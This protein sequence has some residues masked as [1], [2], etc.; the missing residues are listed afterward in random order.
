MTVFVH[1][2]I[3]LS[4]E[5]RNGW[6]GSGAVVLSRNGLRRARQLDGF[7]ESDVVINLGLVP[8]LGV[9]GIIYNHSDSVRATL[10]PSAIRKT[11]PDLIPP[12]PKEPGTPYWVKGP[13]ERGHNKTFYPAWPKHVEWALPEEPGFDYQTHIE[14]TEFRVITVGD[15]VVQSYKKLPPIDGVRQWEWVGV[16]GIKDGGIIPLV[17]RAVALVPNGNKC[18]FGWDV[19]A[20]QTSAYIIEGNSSPGV[21]AETAQRIVKQI[22]KLEN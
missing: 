5:S 19:I 6:M 12:L 21:S 2:S 18:V 16:K 3:P 15:M 8:A 10:T 22:S 1:R 20:N 7:K 14:G 4:Q 13:G 9:N 11:M 17:K